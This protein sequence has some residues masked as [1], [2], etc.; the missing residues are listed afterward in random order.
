MSDNKIQVELNVIDNMSNELKAI[1]SNMERNFEAQNTKLKESQGAFSNLGQEIKGSFVN[2]VKAGIIAYAGFEVINKVTANFKMARS[3]YKESALAQNQLYFAIGK[4]SGVLNEQSNVIG[5]KLKIDNDEVTAIQ[6][7]I[8]V[9]VKNEQQIRSII[10][11][12]MDLGAYLGSNEAAAQMIGRAFADDA[13][14]LGRLKIKVEGSAGSFE[15]LE[16]IM[17]GVNRQFG[18]QAEAS[19]EVKDFWD[20]LSLSWKESNEY[21]YKMYSQLVNIDKVMSDKKGID[22]LAEAQYKYNLK[23]IE[24]GK[25]IDGQIAS[26]SLL[27]KKREEIAKYQEQRN[28]TTGKIA[29][30][31]AMDRQKAENEASAKR[32]AKAQEEADKQL[33]IQSDAYIKR[34]TQEREGDELLKAA[35]NERAAWEREIDEAA[36]AG[37]QKHYD[38]VLKSNMD[39]LEKSSDDSFK[40][41]VDD[42]QEAQRH[43]ETMVA[44]YSSMSQQMGD[45]IARAMEDGNINMKKIFKAILNIWLSFI[46]RQMVASIFANAAEKFATAGLP[47]LFI[48]GLEAT[49]ITAAFEI[50]KGKI[51]AFGGGGDFLTSGPQM[52]MVGDNPGGRERV[53]VTPMSSPN[54]SG[55]QDNRSYGGNS[56][57]IHLHDQSGNIVDTV[58]RELRRGGSGDKLVTYLSDRMA[59]R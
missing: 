45:A 46:E 47:G 9:Y 57:T 13:A 27:D 15:R 44:I 4:V 52:I 49:A 22:L 17:K 38:F 26:E 58:Y 31:Q 21:L 5:K 55:P 16:S 23:I 33:K 25:T 42:E 37:K 43:S 34:I 36:K 2:A 20:A 48:A 30:G 12:I 54:Y 39:S 28:L 18:G 14:E 32:I 35:H 56:M 53:Q 59:A 6:A 10:P 11:A 51:S 3:E 50:A 29:L 19:A 7:K 41:W 40:K 1:R 8:G 24:T